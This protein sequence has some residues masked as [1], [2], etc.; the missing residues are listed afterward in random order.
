MGK[1]VYEE[2]GD[3]T[4]V[5]RDSFARGL[6]LDELPVRASW[7]D[8]SGAHDETVVE[9]ALVGSAPTCHLV[10]GDPTVSRLHAELAVRHGELWVRDLDSR[11]GTYVDGVRVGSALVRD[12]SVLRV[13]STEIRLRHAGPSRTPELWPHDR[14]GSLVG[15]SAAMRALFAKLARVAPT[16]ATVLIQGE[17]GTG[18]ELVARAIHDAS[19]RKDGPYVIVDGAAL[20]EGV[21]ETEL[22]GHAKGA[23]T[24]A[25]SARVGAIEAAHGG[26]VF[27]DEVGEL[28]LSMQP[29]LLRAIESRMVRPVGETQYRSVDVR[30]C[31]ATHRDLRS[32]VSSGAFREDLYFRLAVVMIDV[33]PLRARPEDIPLLVEHFLPAGAPMPPLEVIRELA[34]RPWIGNARELRNAVDRLVALGPSALDEVREPPRVRADLDVPID[35]PLRDVRAAFVESVEREY[36]RAR[37]SGTAATSRPSRASPASTARTSTSSCASTRSELRRSSQRARKAA[38]SSC[39]ASIGFATGIGSMRGTRGGS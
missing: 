38:I 34:E 16:E 20:A 23:Y 11:N 8:A 2:G 27:L 7:V 9:G 6:V 26:T 29:K 31:C 30:F 15:R 1:L 18:K 5:S 22:F 36:L 37:S 35:R 33:P 39:T 13:G 12:R 25:A 17:T 4:E 21:L 3:D 32:L 24:G 10:V 19:S 14:F 28:P